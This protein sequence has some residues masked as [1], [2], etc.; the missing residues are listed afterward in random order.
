[1]GKPIDSRALAILKKYEL[2]QKDDQG[3]YK[4]LWDCHGSWV[5]YHRY[6]ELAGAKNGIK[7]KFWS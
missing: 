3:Q 7:Y 2:D 5:M 6:I 4:A 1:M